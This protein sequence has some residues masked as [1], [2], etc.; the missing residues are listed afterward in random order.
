[1]NSFL[2]ALAMILTF[3]SNFVS[4]QSVF[5]IPNTAPLYSEAN[6]QSEVL[7]ELE[8]GTELK[9]VLEDQ[10]GFLL[11][12]YN[13]MQGYIYS[14]LVGESTQEQDMVLSY[15]AT[16]L[17][18]TKIYSLTT[19]EI[20]CDLEKGKRVFI[21][22]GYDDDKD[23]LAVQFEKDGKILYG[24]VKIEDVKPDGVNTALIVSITAIVAIVSIIIILLGLSNKKRHKK[25]KNQT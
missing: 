3:S 5:V 24:L 12:E 15:N 20:I 23:M 25:L 9:I 6:F 14:E 10:N 1:M 2:F 13:D 7:A 11:V 18:D 22:Q 19:E 21:Y 16:I 4:G 17:N 8:K